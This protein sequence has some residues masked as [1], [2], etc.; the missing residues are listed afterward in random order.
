MLRKILKKSALALLLIVLLLP[1]FLI[2]LSFLQNPDIRI[3]H[4]PSGFT[5]S[6]VEKYSESCTFAAKYK[7]DVYAVSAG[8]L[9]TVGFDI[10]IGRDFD[11]GIISR[12]DCVVAVSKSYVL[13]EFLTVDVLGCTVEINKVQYK[14]SAVFDDKTSLL[15]NIAGIDFSY[16]FFIPYTSISDYGDLKVDAV[17]CNGEVPEELS[18]RLMKAKSSD[19]GYYKKQMRV[20]QYVLLLALAGMATVINLIKFRKSQSKWIFLIL[21]FIIIMLL[22]CAVGKLPSDAVPQKGNVFET[23]YHLEAFEGVV[24]SLLNGNI[25]TA[26][27]LFYLYKI[28][29]TIYS[30]VILTGIAVI[31]KKL[32]S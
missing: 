27:K 24:E 25:R 2:P 10:I 29:I 31:N 13:E 7:T 23:E 32:T 11:S 5:L 8:F 9:D 14:I 12:G 28:A 6:D 19:I 18:L 30:I 3:W 21:L 17:V 4:S 22:I 20:T 15:E 16:T 26:P 1:I